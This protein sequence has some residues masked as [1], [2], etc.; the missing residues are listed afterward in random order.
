MSICWTEELAVGH[1]KMDRDHRQLVALVNDL[2]NNADAALFDWR[3]DVLIKHTLAHFELEED[4]MRAA[5]YPYLAA[6]ADKHRA[7]IVQIRILRT[8]LAEGLVDWSPEIAT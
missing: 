2:F 3:M 1:A 8:S 4:L 5:T 6:H 7:L